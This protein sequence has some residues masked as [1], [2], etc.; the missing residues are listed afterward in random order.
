MTH[1]TALKQL[2]NE[3]IFERKI[4]QNGRRDIWQRMRTQKSQGNNSKNCIKTK[5]QS[6]IRVTKIL[7]TMQNGLLKVE[8]DQ[9]VPYK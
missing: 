6:G 8:S 1:Q 5:A 7:I 9:K 4:Y 2:F 3:V